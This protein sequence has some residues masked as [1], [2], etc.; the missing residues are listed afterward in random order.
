M[1]EAGQAPEGGPPLDE[2]TTARLRGLVRRTAPRDGHATRAKNPKAIFILG[3]PRSGTTLLRVML[4]GHPRLFAPPELELLPFDTLKERRGFFGGGFEFW[5][6]GVTRAVMELKGC[7]GAAAERFLRDAED[8]GMPVTELYG[9]VQKLLGGRTLVD[10]SPSYALDAGVLERAEQLFEEPLYL[11][12]LRHPSAVTRSFEE[13]KL[14]LATP[15]FFTA[16]PECT[17]QQLAEFVWLLCH[18][19]IQ[20]FLQKVPAHRQHRVSFERLVTEPRTNL[21]GIC[22]FLGLN[23]VPDM[24]NPYQEKQRRMTDGVSGLSPM[25]GDPKFHRHEGI[26]ASAADRWRKYNVPDFLSPRTWAM[27]ES[28]GY[29]HEGPAREQRPPET[30]GSTPE[31]T[32][33]EAEALLARLDQLSDEQV[34]ALLNDC[35]SKRRSRGARD[36]RPR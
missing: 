5:L 21:E 25:V 1:H 20:A 32:S 13:A 34:E 10:K 30:D 11:Y 28:L 18:E 14:H 3:P 12:L 2:G 6:Q 4:G 8:A 23:F 22:H 17:P 36:G 7:D 33:Q 24:A 29:E 15:V 31:L 16:P 35:E 26:N 27:A 19:N 9:L